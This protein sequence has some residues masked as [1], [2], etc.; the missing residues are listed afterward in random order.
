M[1]KASILRS[2]FMED[3]IIKIQDD[4][5]GWYHDDLID[6]LSKLLKESDS[7]TLERVFNMVDDSIQV[8]YDCDGWFDL[9]K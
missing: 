6:F 8:K 4:W 5:D 1:L 3:N 7:K 9:V 2:T